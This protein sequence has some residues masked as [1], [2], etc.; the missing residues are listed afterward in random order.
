LFPIIEIYAKEK[1]MKIKI[2]HT[3]IH[4]MNNGD[5]NKNIIKLGRAESI[6]ML[7]LVIDRVSAM[8]KSSLLSIKKYVW[9]TR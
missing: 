5:N 9:H 8:T 1:D 4:F 3:H 7:F 6:I 2:S